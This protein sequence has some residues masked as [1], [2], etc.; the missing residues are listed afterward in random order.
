MQQIYLLTIR[1]AAASTLQSADDAHDSVFTD[2][3]TGP[4]THLQDP[5]ET[6]Q[7]SSSN[8]RTTNEAE[9]SPRDS[10]LPSTSD[11]AGSIMDESAGSASARSEPSEDEELAAPDSGPDLDSHHP[12]VPATTDTVGPKDLQHPLPERPPSA[13]THPS[14][15]ISGESDISYHQDEDRATEESSAASEAY[16][17]PEPEAD[18]QS[19]GS[20]YSPPFSPAPPDPVESM[21]ASTPLS[22][23]SQADEALTDDPQ[24]SVSNRPPDSQAG[25]LDV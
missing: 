18:A 1:S 5:P 25:V 16:E 21:A 6:A 11:S 7:F 15:D 12:P 8:P 3:E 19:G 23:L 2:A 14:K 4:L 13:A 22:D 17:P 20:A 24:V 10:S 9:E